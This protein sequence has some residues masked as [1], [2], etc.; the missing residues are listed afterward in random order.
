MKSIKRFWTI[1]ILID[2]T[3]TILAGHAAAGRRRSASA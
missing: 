3:G 2:E 1:P